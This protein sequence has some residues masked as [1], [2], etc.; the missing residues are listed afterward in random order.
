M[1]GIYNQQQSVGN[2]E[3]DGGARSNSNE[4]KIVRFEEDNLRRTNHPMVKDYGLMSIPETKTPFPRHADP[5]AAEELKRRLQEV[6]HRANKLKLDD[7]QFDGTENSTIENS[8][9]RASKEEEEMY[10][11]QHSE[12][13]SK[14]KLFYRSEYTIAKQRNI[15]MEMHLPG[16]AVGNKWRIDDGNE[17]PNS[18][19]TVSGNQQITSFIN[20]QHPLN[21]TLLQNQDGKHSD[22]DRTI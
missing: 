22:M 20:G 1:S 10:G 3:N 13:L 9:Q 16:P 5:V 17:H 8:G 2:E 14:R 6:L 11:T 12:F 19:S 18:S 4:N 15:S 21:L 7:N